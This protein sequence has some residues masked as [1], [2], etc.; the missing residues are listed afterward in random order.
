MSADLEPRS[1]RAS[2][3]RVLLILTESGGKT[4]G[5]RSCRRCKSRMSTRERVRV[6]GMTRERVR[7]Q[8][9]EDAVSLVRSAPLSAALA[10]TVSGCIRWR[11]EETRCA[12]LVAIPARVVGRSSINHQILPSPYFQR[13]RTVGGRVGFPR[14]RSR[15]RRC[16]G[17]HERPS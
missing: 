3:R 1:S 5:V 11:I 14:A 16:E 7:V 6:Q 15:T 2:P 10:I 9:E 4:K 17:R 12:S 8:G 13:D